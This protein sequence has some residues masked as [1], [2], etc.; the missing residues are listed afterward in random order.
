L[1]KAVTFGSAHEAA[2]A[3]GLAPPALFR[4]RVCGRAHRSDAFAWLSCLN[5]LY[6]DLLC[7]LLGPPV[8][9][10]PPDRAS[11]AFARQAW[12]AWGAEPERKLVLS[13]GCVRPWFLA[14]DREV[15]VRDLVAQAFGERFR[16]LEE[17]ARAVSAL[18]AAHLR[19]V[20]ELEGCLAARRPPARIV[21]VSPFAQEVMWGIAALEVE[22]ALP[23]P[24]LGAGRTVEVPQAALLAYGDNLDRV[25]WAGYGS[26]A[27]GFLAVEGSWSRYFEYFEPYGLPGQARWLPA[28]QGSRAVWDRARVSGLVRDLARRCGC[29]LEGEGI[30]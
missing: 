8:E 13:L 6:R 9:V 15:G 25:L 18:K 28:G 24:H 22:P 21:R 7:A 14:V 29:R 5:R 19:W 4:C 1:R 16:E 20:G 17:K 3:F 27:F 2:A 23:F 10:K 26:R 30:T 11:L 12:F